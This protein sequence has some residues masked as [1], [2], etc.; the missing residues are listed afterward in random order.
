TKAACLTQQEKFPAGPYREIRDSLCS[1]LMIIGQYFFYGRREHIAECRR[2]NAEPED[3]NDQRHEHR[4]F[5][6]VQIRHYL[7]IGFF[8]R[9]VE[10]TAVKP[11]HI[12]RAQ[13]D[14][15]RCDKGQ[16]AIDEIGALQGKKLADK[17]A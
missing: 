4:I 7:Y 15:E 14:A 5:A 2:M 3:K 6:H 13:N 17:T 11:Q 10:Q 1:L 12:T 9:A 16:P 8:Q